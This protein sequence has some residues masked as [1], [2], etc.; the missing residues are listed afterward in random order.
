MPV[1]VGGERPGGRVRLARSHLPG[2]TLG[3]TSG[4]LEG[5][6]LE[7]GFFGAAL[8]LRGV[9]QREREVDGAIRS[10]TVAI[11]APLTSHQHSVPRSVKIPSTSSEFT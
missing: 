11:V 8:Q 10:E 6:S 4:S 7:G 3:A 1:T 5:G 9:R 2:V